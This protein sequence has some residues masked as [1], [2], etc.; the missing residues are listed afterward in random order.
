MS[1]R[2]LQLTLL[3]YLRLASAE[4][5]PAPIALVELVRSP[6]SSVEDLRLMLLTDSVEDP[7]SPSHKDTQSNETIS[8]IPRSLGVQPAQQALCKVRT[9]VLE[10]TR[11]MLDRRNANFLLWPPCVEVQ[12]CSGCCNTK[13][14][15]CVPTLRHTRY[16]QVMKIQYVNKQ[17]YYEKAVI[18][19]VD[20]V[21]CHCQ[22][23]APLVAPQTTPAKPPAQRQTPW[24]PK[25]KG[26]SKEEL[27][28]QDELKRNQQVQL[29]DGAE[30][31]FDWSSHTPTLGLP[32]LNLTRQLGRGGSQLMPEDSSTH[33]MEE[34][35]QRD[36]Q[37]PHFEISQSPQYDLPLSEGLKRQEQ[38]H[39]SAG[40]DRRGPKHQLLESLERGG[41]L[42]H[43][44]GQPHKKQ[45][46]VS[47][48]GKE[49]K[50]E[51]ESGR[52]QLQSQ[53][54]HHP[55]HHHPHQQAETQTTTERAATAAP[56]PAHAPPASSVVHPL[57]RQESSRKKR[58]KSRN[59]ISKASMRALLM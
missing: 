12:R 44:A 7:N 11:T 32:A 5:D 20:H 59:R 4:G 49:K 23:S 45:R 2:L 18:P 31:G 46:V 13:S 8:R 34:L 27:H 14:L 33:V 17:P 16:L 56:S 29:A 25:A 57:S 40:G 43:P 24:Y 53:Y 1:V 26:H 38:A 10:V 21:E 51:L 30:P 37:F 41:G 22:R 54:L 47:I 9:E 19:I 3:A 6:V 50:H 35:S 42:G 52:S 15:Q 36:S 48:D 55:P 39:D 28:R 58:R